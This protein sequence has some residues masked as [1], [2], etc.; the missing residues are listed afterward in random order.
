MFGGIMVRTLYKLPP[1]M[2]LDQALSVPNVI[3]SCILSFGLHQSQ[4][5]KYV[6]YAP[7]LTG[8]GRPYI[9]KPTFL[10]SISDHV[11]G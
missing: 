9:Q 8:K 5:E 4:S 2:P 1:N 10:T 6:I 7:C 3:R 11:R